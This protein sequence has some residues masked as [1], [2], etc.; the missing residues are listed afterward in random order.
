METGTTLY[1]LF[2]RKENKDNITRMGKDIVADAILSIVN[3][4]EKTN[5]LSGISPEN[6]DVNSN[7]GVYT[8]QENFRLNPYYLAPEKILSGTKETDNSQLYTLASLIYFVIY[9]QNYYEEKNVSITA[10]PEAAHLAAP[11]LDYP[12]IPE[13]NSA[14]KKLSDFSPF[15][16]R[17]GMPDLIR[18]LSSIPSVAHFVFQA[19]SDR[20]T[21]DM[22]IPFTGMNLKTNSR[23]AVKDTEQFVK[24]FVILK[25]TVIP[26]RPGTHSY[27]ISARFCPYAVFGKTINDSLARSAVNS[28]LVI[29]CLD[30]PEKITSLF[31][32]NRSDQCGIVPI[33]RTNRTFYQ[34]GV[35]SGSQVPQYRFLFTVPAM[36]SVNCILKI[37]CTGSNTV[38]VAVCD[39][40][41]NQPL[42]PVRENTLTFQL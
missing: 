34:I 20:H 36:S 24:Q 15:N 5:K 16:R 23:L 8:A 1:S 25:D 19:G 3:L 38:I 40:R 10:L 18:F 28:L 31:T 17:E 9:G 29:R 39:K 22:N 41:T 11:L 14:L 2:K 32:I 7:T 33:N 27:T 13:L 30:E 4:F 6:I 26:F 12:A 21:A 37:Y 42:E 35:K